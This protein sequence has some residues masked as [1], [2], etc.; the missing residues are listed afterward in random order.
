[1]KKPDIILELKRIVKNAKEY[2]IDSQSEIDGYD[3]L[4]NDIKVLIAKY[5]K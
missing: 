4:L 2:E 3:Y 1:M 5:T